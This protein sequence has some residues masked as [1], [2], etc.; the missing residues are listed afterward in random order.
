MSDAKI[1]GLPAA[2]R[3]TTAPEL[4]EPG[5]TKDPDD[6]LI[7]AP[8]YR[9]PPIVAALLVVKLDSPVTDPPVMLTLLAF[10]VDMVPSELISALVATAVAMLLNSVSIS[11]PLTIFNGLPLAK[12]SLEVKFVDLT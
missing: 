3:R 1:S 10:C 11:V 6:E 9:Y 8:E 5:E 12:L 2:S 7:T 4:P